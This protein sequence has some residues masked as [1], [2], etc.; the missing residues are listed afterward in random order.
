VADSSVVCGCVDRVVDASAGDWSTEICEH[1]VTVRLRRILRTPLRQKLFHSWMERDVSVGV[2][3]S[4]G[5]SEP[6]GL[7]DIGDGVA[8]ESEDDRPRDFGQWTRLE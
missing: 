3:L 8:R 6:A 4:D 1:E 2:Q 5:C 7:P